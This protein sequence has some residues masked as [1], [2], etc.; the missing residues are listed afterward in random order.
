MF[1]S[2]KEA[3]DYVGGLSSPSKMPCYSYSIPAWECKVGSK[4]REIP[5]S[6]C[7]TCYA[8][9]GRYVFQNVKDAQYRRFGTLN[10]EKWV[11]SFVY[12]I[13][14]KAMT[15]FRWH[16]AGDLQSVQH[17][18]NIVEVAKR[19][20]NCKFWLPTRE[21][22][23]VD[24]YLSTNFE[25]PS[26]LT[27]RVSAT[28]IDGKAPTQF[29]EKWNL[30]GSHVTT[31]ESKVNCHSFKNEGKCGDCRACWDKTVADIFYKKH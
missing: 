14:E 13:T 24:E 7:S 3:S 5:N 1:N 16:D 20:P 21:I 19:C 29:I 10:N 11:E 6:V 12:M 22:E 31:D 9:K 27:I 2:F 28:M 25:V 17:L 23:I 18:A 15:Y 30:V 4:L 26:N 8:R